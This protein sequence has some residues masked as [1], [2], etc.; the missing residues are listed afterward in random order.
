MQAASNAQWTRQI[1]GSRSQTGVKAEKKQ[2][3][4]KQPLTQSCEYADGKPKVRGFIIPGNQ[5]FQK[6]KKQDT[7][8]MNRVI[9]ML[10]VFAL[11]S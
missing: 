3:N 4:Y 10:S 11:S 9:L 8:H 6:Q 5:R 1:Y 2:E 7:I